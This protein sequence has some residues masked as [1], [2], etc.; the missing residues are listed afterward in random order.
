MKIV[1]DT[2]VL[3]AA[4]VA[5]GLCRDIVKRR[6]PLHDLFTSRGLLVELEDTLRRKLRTEP[7]DVP[8]VKAY[9]ARAVLVTPS[10]LKRRICR[11]PDD[12]LVL[13]TAAAANAHCI[14]T[15]DEDL[16]VL[17]RYEGIAIVSPRT[18]VEA[19]A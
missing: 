13:A 10:K 3:I 4:L 6:L 12:D 17:G 1:C 8:F 14:L 11:D 7:R 18:F 2:N 16:L 15:G 9:K 19:T 5:D